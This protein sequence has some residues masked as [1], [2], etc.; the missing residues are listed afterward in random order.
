MWK[1]LRKIRE[2]CWEKKIVN[3]FFKGRSARFFLGFFLLAGTYRGKSK[4]FFLNSFFFLFTSTH[5]TT[6]QTGG[7]GW[8]VVNSPCLSAITTHYLTLAG[9]PH[10]FSLI[11]SII[12]FIFVVYVLCSRNG[13]IVGLQ[14]PY[15]WSKRFMMSVD[16]GCLY[17]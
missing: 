17:L 16:N 13:G 2:F 4:V 15:F 14:F 10:F 7:E 11:L 5:F 3:I 1:I 12:S 8:W 6:R 9:L